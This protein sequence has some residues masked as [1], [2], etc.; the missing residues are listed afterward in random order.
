MAMVWSWRF[1]L[2]NNRLHHDRC[3]SSAINNKVCCCWSV[4][5][6]S[7]ICLFF[8]AIS[9]LRN[10][11]I[12]WVSAVGSE[13][14]PNCAEGMRQALPTFSACMVRALILWRTALSLMLR[15]S[16]VS[17]T[18]KCFLSIRNITVISGKGSKYENVGV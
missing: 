11:I 6:S 15:C 4:L 13:S 2:V 16:A 1:I 9:D 10:S 8:S 12:S 18:D 17:L 14:S 5:V 3:L 7:A